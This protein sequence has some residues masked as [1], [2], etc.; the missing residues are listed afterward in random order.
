MLTTSL[1]LALAL[2]ADPS[3]APS[4]PQIPLCEVTSIDDQAIPGADA[5]VLM[6]LAVKEG[7]RVAK[8][9]EIGRI[10]D[11]EARAQLDVKQFE[12][13]VANQTANSDIDI[14]HAKAAALVAKAAYDKLEQ[15]NKIF[16]GT[17]TAIDILKN[18][19]EWKKS[20]LAIEQVTEK[21]VEA[22][23]TAKAKSAEVGAAKVAL[24]RHILRAP[25]DGVVVK[26]AKKPGEWISPGE[27]VV[28]LVGI[29]RLRVMGNLDAT[30][31]GPADIDNRKVTV[32]VALPRGRTVSVPGKVVYV[33]PVVTLGRLSVWAE[34]QAPLEDGL[35][36][37]RAGLPAAM[38]VHVHQPVAAVAP[39]TPVRNTSTKSTAKN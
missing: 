34:I 31:W 7:M 25:F 3:P 18:R 35:P 1:L 15:S 4:D 9:A 16:P 21:Q 11:S 37:V 22:Q 38:T 29:D 20:E 36:V 30:D 32:E 24:D 26:V 12:Y 2:A 17:V 23:L 8:G 6:L 5:G 33:S 19:L 27:P 39:T 10:D 14:R 28:T 13:E